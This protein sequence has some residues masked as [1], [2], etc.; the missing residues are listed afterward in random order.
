LHLQ[1]Y[2]IC[3]KYSYL[4]SMC[5]FGVTRSRLQIKVE[6]LMQ[7]RRATFLHRL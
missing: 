4:V 6:S 7:Y 5:D 1:D 3:A 2:V